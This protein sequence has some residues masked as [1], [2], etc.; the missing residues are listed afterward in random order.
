MDPFNPN[1]KFDILNYLNDLYMAKMAP[2]IDVMHSGGYHVLHEGDEKSKE[3]QIL[4]NN[5][6]RINI[7]NAEIKYF[8]FGQQENI[9][10]YNEPQDYTIR[11]EPS[12]EDGK[13][14]NE[15]SNETEQERRPRN[16]LTTEV[17]EI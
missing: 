16:S 9:K 7:P 10:E 3:E 14:Y 13:G 17:I 8:S 6:K 4:E 15:V 1:N 12:G 2:Q 5:K 11:D